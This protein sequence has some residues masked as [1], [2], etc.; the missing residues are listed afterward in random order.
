MSGSKNSESWC[1]RTFVVIGAAFPRVLSAFAS[2]AFACNAMA[3]DA[4]AKYPQR[5]LRM[6]VPY[7]AGGNGDIMARVVAQGLAQRIGQQVVVDNRGGATGIIGMEIAAKAPADGYTLLFVANGIA[8]NVVFASKLPYDTLHDLAPLTLT[9]NT[10]I[11]LVGNASLPAK[12]V[13]ELIALA[14]ARPGELNYGTSGNGSTGNLAGELFKLMAGVN[15]VHVPYKA[16]AQA[17]TD[18]I[19][20]QLQLAFP[21]FTGVLPHVRSGK[22]RGIGLTSAQRSPL[23]PDIPTVAESGV[24]GYEAGIWN[25]MLVRAG[26]PQAIVDYLSREIVAVIDSPHTRERFAALGADPLTSTPDGFA[27]YIRAEIAK[28]SKVA[29]A[30]DIRIDLTQ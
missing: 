26:T 28:W 19:G 4:P 24:P 8:T 9:G 1:L 29:K 11:L 18:V 6:V 17:V 10:P 20:G 15:L 27:R 12:N 3:A 5:P 30:A 14:K 25:G 7:A 2:I 13:K 22:L 16:T 23:A 21:G